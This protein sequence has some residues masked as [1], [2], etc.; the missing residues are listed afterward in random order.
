LVTTVGAFIVFTICLAGCGLHSYHV[1]RRVGIESA[2][3]Y[4]VDNGDIELDDE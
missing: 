2:I 1:G 4:M 3:D